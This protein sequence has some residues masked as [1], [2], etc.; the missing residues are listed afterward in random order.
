[1]RHEHPCIHAAFT[2][3]RCDRVRYVEGAVCLRRNQK[4]KD[5]ALAHL[6]QNI[7]LGVHGAL[8]D[9]PLG[10]DAHLG[11][12]QR[13]V[14][15]GKGAHMLSGMLGG[16]GVQGCHGGGDALLVQVTHQRPQLGHCRA[17]PRRHTARVQNDPAMAR[18]QQHAHLLGQM[19]SHPK[20]HH[21]LQFKHG[22]LVHARRQPAVRPGT[23]QAPRAQGH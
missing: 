3:A 15:V 18:K 10:Q 19:G 14:Q 23:A 11:P 2:Q 1:M 22:H 12:F 6:A 13:P 21:A 9:G 17:V 5:H 7:P 4:S 20:R 8:L 16:H